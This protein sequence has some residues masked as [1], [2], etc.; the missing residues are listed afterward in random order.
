MAERGG[1]LV[2]A[3]LVLGGAGV[4]IWAGITD[5][6]GGVR[7]GIRRAMAGQPITKRTGATG[8]ASFLTTLASI[9]PTGAGTGGAGGGSGKYE[10][11]A[12]R[13]HVK[14]AAAEVGGRFNIA[15]VYGYSMRN[16][17]GT[18]TLSD[19][20]RG[21]ALDFM[22]RTGSAL[23][24]YVVGNAGRLAVTYV[25]WNRRIWSVERAAE[26]WRPYNG[27]S[28]HTD[29]VHVSFKATQAVST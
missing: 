3:L 29:H 9:G 17:A 10:L 5:P 1:N 19:H 23:A 14:A 6:D 11:G 20:A 26:G 12:V 18:N 22:T 28:P 7:E 25:I 16:V 24:E 13:P 8:G 21:L 2:L 4:A 15:T 27:V